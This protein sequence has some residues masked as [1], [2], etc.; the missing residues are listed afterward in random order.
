MKVRPNLIDIARQ[1]GVHVSTVSRA[2]NGHDSIPADT[3]ARILAVANSLGYRMDPLI[4]ALMRSRRRGRPVAH[5]ANLGFLVA[6]SRKQAWRP[7]SW[8]WEVFAGAKEYAQHTGYSLEVFWG[9]ELASPPTAFNRMLQARGIQGLI[10]AP[11]HEAPLSFNLAWEHFSVLSLHYGTSKVV[12][13]FH[14]LVSNH[15]QSMIDVCQRCRELGYDRVGL[16]LRDHPDTHYEYG[17]LILGAYMAAMDETRHLHAILPL[18]TRELDA[19]EIAR[20]AREQQ[21]DVI[22]QAGGG[23]S[24]GF[25]PPDFIQRLRH[26]GF[27]VG[28]QQG[29]VI[30]G[31]RNEFDMAVVDERT[32]AIGRTASQLLIEYIQQNQRGV[33][34]DPFVYQL[35]SRFHDGRTLPSRRRVLLPAAQRPDDR[36]DEPS[37]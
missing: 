21:V 10:L 35:A 33:P 13:R 27:D 34:A 19:L 15:F 9:S 8:I 20:W 32:H 22:V 25:E 5:K 26:H 14:Q 2:L 4:A 11:E 7:R 3:R 16:V 12:P 37:S 28:G 29:L 23:F 6:E 17:R 24:P 1:A 31:H 30:M 36:A 18:A